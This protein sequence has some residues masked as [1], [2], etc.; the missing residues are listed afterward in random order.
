MDSSLASMDIRVADMND[1]ADAADLVAFLDAYASDPM[2]GGHPLP[3]DVKER[4]PRDLAGRPTSLVLLA[5]IEGVAAGAA[6]CF[7]GYSTFAASPLLNLHDFVVAP[8]FRGRGVARAMLDTLGI[9]ARR[10]GCC[11][12]TL[13]VL[14]NNHRARG[15]YEAAGFVGYELDPR[16]GQAIFLHKK[17]D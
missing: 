9:E 3:T 6:V 4:L 16:A 12:I 1:P 13:E 17:I 2:G 14:S 7:E 5:S 11:K 8:A 10:R 15:I